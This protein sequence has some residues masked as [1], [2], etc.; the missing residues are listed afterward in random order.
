MN[1]CPICG[2]TAEPIAKIERMSDGSDGAGVVWVCPDC[3]YVYMGAS[4]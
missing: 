3:G 4:E 2:S 1:T